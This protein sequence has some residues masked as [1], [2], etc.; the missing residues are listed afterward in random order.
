[1]EVC[2]G[3]PADIDHWMDLVRPG[4][5][6]FPGAGNRRGPGGAQTDGPEVYGKAAGIVCES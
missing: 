5:L 2:F 4:Q 3:M 6:E 1:M